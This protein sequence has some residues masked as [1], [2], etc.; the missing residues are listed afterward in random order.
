MSPVSSTPGVNVSTGHVF[1]ILRHIANAAAPLGV[2]EIARQLGL[3]TTTVHRA[4]VTLDQ[5]EFAARMQTAPRYELGPMPQ[6]LARAL[7]RRLPLRA[8]ALPYLARIAHATGETT[9]LGVRLGWYEVR[10][11]VA[12]GGRDLHSPGRLGEIALLH[13]SAA[14]PAILAFLTARERTRYRKYVSSRHAPLLR[15]TERP[16]IRRALH[17]ARQRGFAAI[18]LDG[19]APRF[20]LAF[21]LRAPDGGAVASVLVNGPVAS[22]AQETLIRPAWAEAIDELE[23]II[24]ADPAILAHPY[25]HLDPDDLHFELR[26]PAAA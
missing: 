10:V 19:A 4:L 1:D 8:A 16:E 20:A 7:F 24:K 22:G 6:V 25:A 23:R 21:P 12:Y 3:P 5:T 13:S 26:A 18:R 9:S 2:A 14:S 15:Q 17:F 11:A